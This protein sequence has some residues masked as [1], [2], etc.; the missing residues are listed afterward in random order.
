M[1]K[2]TQALKARNTRL[3]AMRYIEESSS[4]D[5]ELD[6]ARRPS[7]SDEEKPVDVASVAASIVDVIIGEKKDAG[8]KKRKVA[9]ASRLLVAN[10]DILVAKGR[11]NLTRTGMPSPYMLPLAMTI[12][13][14]RVK[15]FSNFP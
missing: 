3:S 6:F 11:K 10:K 8:T 15:R 5:A 13:A 2:T 4:S 1:W 7:H 9:G 12:C 14:S